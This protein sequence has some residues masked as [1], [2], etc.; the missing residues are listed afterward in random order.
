MQCR[1][2]PG[3]IISIL[4]SHSNGLLPES[5]TYYPT[6]YCQILTGA[7][8]LIT[9]PFSRRSTGISLHRNKNEVVGDIRLEKDE[10]T[11]VIDIGLGN[12]LSKPIAFI[13]NYS[14]EVLERFELV[15]GI[16]TIPN[17][18]YRMKNYSIRI[19]NDKNIVTQKI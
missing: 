10:D 16:N 5:I 14:G 17:A 11:L 18:G 15:P 19:V 3:S 12:E 4:F 9:A 1:P 8:R 7:C 6:I 2:P 13:I